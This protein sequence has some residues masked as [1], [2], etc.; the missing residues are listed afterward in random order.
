MGEAFSSTSAHSLRG[1]IK[2][3]S[4]AYF[5]NF[6]R[7]KMEDICTMV[8]NEMWQKCPVQKGFAI[9]DIKEFKNFTTITIPIPKALDDSQK[10]TQNNFFDCF[11]VKGNPFK[12]ENILKASQENG[13]KTAAP[14]NGSSTV[15]SLSGVGELETDCCNRNQRTPTIPITM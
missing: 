13:A 8:E 11:L 3:Q 5:C 15:C 12:P 2:Q 9:T 10:T 6:H 14:S 4:K 1:S 7:Q